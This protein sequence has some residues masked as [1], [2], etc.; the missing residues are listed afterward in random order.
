ML[1][2]VVLDQTDDA[3]QPQRLHTDDTPAPTAQTCPRSAAAAK[4][5]D[6]QPRSLTAGEGGAVLLPGS[7]PPRG[8][9]PGPRASGLSPVVS[10][11]GAIL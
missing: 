2:G 10:V 5:F 11:E 6:S 7:M 9:D 1:E 3:V 8:L 4:T